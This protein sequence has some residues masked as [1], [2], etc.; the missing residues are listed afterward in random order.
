V[1]HQQQRAPRASLK[2]L[3]KAASVKPAKKRKKYDS[4]TEDTSSHAAVT[5]GSEDADSEVDITPTSNEKRAAT[6]TRAIKTKSG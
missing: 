5:A 6:G 3:A 4:A 1:L 2:D